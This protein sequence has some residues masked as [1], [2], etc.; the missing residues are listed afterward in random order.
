MGTRQELCDLADLLVSTG[1]R[2]M[3]DMVLPMARAR[4][5]FE[6][7]AAGSVHGKIVLTP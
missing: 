2:P 5:A 4:E 6:A 7:M 3:L 1:V